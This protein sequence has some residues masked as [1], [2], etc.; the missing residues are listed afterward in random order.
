MTASD[1]I[2]MDGEAV[3]QVEELARYIA[4]VKS[5]SDADSF[6]NQL[7]EASIAELLKEACNGTL[8]ASP[9]A[10]LEA[11]YNQLFAIVLTQ[12]AG[13]EEVDTYVREIV[14]DLTENV[15]SGAAVLKVLNNLYNLLPA[16]AIRASVFKGIV[17]VAGKTNLLATLLPL[18][19]RLPT[20]FGEWSIESEAKIELLLSIRDSLEAAGLNSEAYETELVFLET[21]SESPEKL[22]QIASSAI[23][24]YVNISAVCDLDALANL[25][26]V[27]ELSKGGKLG[28]AGSLLNTLLSSDFKGWKAYVE[29]NKAQLEALGVDIEKASD[30]MRLLTVASIAADNLG[31]DVPFSTVAEAIE[32]DADEVEV[33]IID[34]IRA[35]LIQGKMNQVTSTV[36]PTRSTYRKFGQEQ[37]AVLAE[38]L[39]QWKASLEKLQPVISNAKLLAQQQAVQMA[40]QAKVTIE[41]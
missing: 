37:W 13:P 16:T 41:K 18:I 20:L 29:A 3:S 28:D 14:A 10:K 12:S 19:S 40:G 9:E 21:V 22:A 5:I 6:V 32:V 2:F 36:L 1:V 17:A 31:Q 11:V 39:A 4:Q 25:P 15:Q 8:A 35:G 24:H 38:R 34:V 7:K 33:W 23:V 27:Q 26:Q 30:K